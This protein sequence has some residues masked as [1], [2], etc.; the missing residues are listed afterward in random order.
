MRASPAGARQRCFPRVRRRSHSNTE[1]EQFAPGCA[2][3]ASS[4]WTILAPTS[5][6]LILC[7]Q[8]QPN[9]LSGISIQ[10]V[11]EADANRAELSVPGGLIACNGVERG[12]GLE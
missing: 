12:T 4:L 8:S 11:A 2:A 9:G 5:P 3:T 10:G 7:S 6:S 1:R